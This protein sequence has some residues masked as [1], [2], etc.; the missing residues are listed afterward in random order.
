MGNT[1]S[2]GG[3]SWTSGGVP[4]SGGTISGGNLSGTGLPGRGGTGSGAGTSTDIELSMERRERNSVNAFL[5]IV[6]TLCAWSTGGA[7]PPRRLRARLTF[8]EL[9]VAIP[10]FKS[11]GACTATRK[12]RNFDIVGCRARC[13]GWQPNPVSGSGRHSRPAGRQFRLTC[14][15]R[16][17]RPTART[18]SEFRGSRNC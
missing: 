7:T 10:N 5:S 8:R 3:G 4:G 16:R 14:Q 15:R 1:G 12:S 18:E 13:R 2:G 11:M 6:L 17:P 9:E